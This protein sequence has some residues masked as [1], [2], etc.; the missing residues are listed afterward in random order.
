M[1]WDMRSVNG[2]MQSETSVALLP[3]PTTNQSVDEHDGHAGHGRD[4]C[5]KKYKPRC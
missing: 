3:R 2:S 4:S 5:R 1:R